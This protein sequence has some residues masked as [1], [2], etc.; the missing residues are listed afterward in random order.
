MQ[1]ITYIVFLNYAV[2]VMQ[3]SFSR[4]CV[5]SPGKRRHDTSP[6]AVI[7]SLTNTRV[8]FTAAAVIASRAAHLCVYLWVT[9]YVTAP[10]PTTVGASASRSTVAMATQSRCSHPHTL[11]PKKKSK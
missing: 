10:T 7:S 6:H 3:Y 2:K 8:H 4:L 11:N 5:Q 1:K 9:P